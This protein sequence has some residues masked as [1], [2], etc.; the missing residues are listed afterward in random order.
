MALSKQ[1]EINFTVARKLIMSTIELGRGRQTSNETVDLADRWIAALYNPKQ[2]T[3]E[4]V[5][6]HQ[7]METVS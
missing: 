2:R 1:V 3:S 5:P 7:P 4:T 6:G